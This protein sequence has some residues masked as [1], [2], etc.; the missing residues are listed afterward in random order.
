MDPNVTAAIV[1]AAAGLAVVGV[2]RAF[3]ALNKR[4]D[5]LAEINVRHLAP[6]RLYCEETF[7]RL[8]EIHRLVN[9]KHGHCEF[10]D[11]VP[12]AEQIST[13][14]TSWFN[15]DGC[16]LVSSAYFNACLFGAI[17]NVRE[18]MPYLK[19]RSGDDTTL[20]NLMFAV[21]RAFLGNLGVFY[22]I[23]HTIGAEMWRHEEQRFLTYREFSERLKTTEDRPWFDRLILFY[24]QAACGKRQDDIHA[25]LCALKSLCEF[26][27]SGVRGGDAIKARLDS[28]GVR[29]A[30]PGPSSV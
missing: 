20:L 23:Q 28:E 9:E 16:Y 2:E 24:L 10:L 27:D 15:S 26:I 8:H 30:S 3:E 5:R 12:N 11:S 18:H 17:K 13:K 21:S 22:A 25:A 14:D 6:L 19:L 29:Y 7:F 4:R 1:G